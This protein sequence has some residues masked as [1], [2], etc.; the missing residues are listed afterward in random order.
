MKPVSRLCSSSMFSNSSPKIVYIILSAT[1]KPFVLL[2]VK[3][4][5]DEQRQ[6]NPMRRAFCFLVIIL[7]FSSC[8]HKGDNSEDKII[9]VSIAPF[10]W[11]VQ[12]IAG[13]DFTVN[14]MVPAG[15]D[16]HTY[17]PFPEQVTRLVGSLGYISNGYLDFE[18]IWLPRFFEMNKGMRI[19]SLADNIDLLGSSVNQ[20]GEK[21]ENADPHFWLSLQCAEEMVPAVKDFLSE[22]NPEGVS[23]YEKNCQDLLMDIRELDFKA[24]DLFSDAEKRTFLIFHPNLG[25]L[26]RD[27]DLNE[28]S[29]EHDGKEPSA[30]VIR[31]IIDLASGEELT[32]I[33]VQNEYDTKN[34]KA[35]ADEIGAELKV[36]DPLSEEWLTTM[37]DIIL[38]L[39]NSLQEK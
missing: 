36:I 30:S 25:Y 31:E 13:D 6:L 16:P 39:Y 11:F 2:Y 35:V 18:K 19:L 12:E 28:I 34:A 33:F 8:N 20:A 21:T 15:A 29:I 23:Q 5:S 37:E 27:Y 26:A 14:V 1:H 22:I 3:F 7:L 17:E 24:R 38:S 10:K 32:T 4:V 9:T